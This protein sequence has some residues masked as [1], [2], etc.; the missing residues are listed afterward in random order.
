MAT[1]GPA[2]QKSRSEIETRNTLSEIGP[3][4]C[5]LTKNLARRLK[6]VV[7]VARL[8]KAVERRLTKNLA[9]RLKL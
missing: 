1:A 9:R 7:R 6:R 3:S 8:A 4:S 5:R 2:H